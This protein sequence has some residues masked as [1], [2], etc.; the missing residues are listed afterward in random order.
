MQQSK[1]GLY[2][3]PKY[4]GQNFGYR[5]RES[6]TAIETNPPNFGYISPTEL[7]SWRSQ[8]LNALALMNLPI[9]ELLS[10]L[11]RNSDVMSRALGI[12]QNLGVQSYEII[13]D[14]DG[15]E[16]DSSVA[17]VKDFINRLEIGNTPFINGLRNDIYNIKIEGAFCRELYFDRPGGTAVGLAP[18]SPF[19]LRFLKTESA[20]HNVYYRIVQY[21]DGNVYDEPIVLQDRENPNPTFVY[22][23]V[24]QIENKPFGTPPFLPAIAGVLSRETMVGYLREILAGASTARGIISI[25][26]TQ[27][28]EFDEKEA[29]KKT[30]N[31]IKSLSENLT[32]SNASQLAV[33]D[34]EFVYEAL[35]AINS[36]GAN[37]AEI[38]FDIVM[39][40]LQYALAVPEA[41][42]KTR[43]RGGLGNN[44]HRSDILV[45]EADLQSVITPIERGYSLLFNEVVSSQGGRAGVRLK[46]YSDTTEIDRIRNEALE[47]QTN[48]YIALE[49]RGIISKT[50]A[51]GLII[52]VDPNMHDFE[53][54]IP[55]EAV[56]T[57]EPEETPNEPTN[58]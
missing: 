19:S 54:D 23:P 57:S 35:E 22:T 29:D 21:K 3:P 6:V 14:E 30:L 40:G 51:R 55:E 46:I 48:R 4:A 26:S 39:R 58:D 2:L 52:Q 5:G 42:L 36:T 53:T 37:G 47:K 31:A 9:P 38:L 43:R 45:F 44:E 28:E 41:I 17:I 1:S 7:G 50:E 34:T 10:T 49:E 13:P 18:I 16:G 12:Y 56:E 27:F 15:A 24:N 32:K 25:P 11:V 8:T 33:I 20:I